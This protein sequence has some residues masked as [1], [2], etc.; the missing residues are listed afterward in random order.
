MTNGAEKM[1]SFIISSA[2]PKDKKDFYTRLYKTY[3]PLMAHTAYKVANGGVNV[4]DVVQDTLLKLLK[5][6]DRLREKSDSALAFHIV[7]VTKTTA[8]DALRKKYRDAKW[9][10]YGTEDDFSVIFT[11]SITPEDILIKREEHGGRMLAL[12]QLPESQ[13]DLLLYKYVLE[14]KNDELARLYGTSEAN[15]RQML[16]RT[17][18]KLCKLL[19]EMQ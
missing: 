9:S 18:R 1:L 13:R 16:S 11:D 7:L 19:E 6:Y 10:Y 15:I 4:D 2:S 8:I 3:Y 5:Q 12:D 17:R 14:L